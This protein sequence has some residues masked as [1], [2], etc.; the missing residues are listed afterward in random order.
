M[1][2]RGLTNDQVAQNF[3]TRQDGY[4]KNGYFRSEMGILYSFDMEIARW[5]D[6]AIEKPLVDSNWGLHQSAT[7]SGHLSVLYWAAYRQKVEMKAYLPFVS[8]TYES[9]RIYEVSNPF[10]VYPDKVD[11]FE[12][13]SK[14]SW[15]R[16]STAFKHALNALDTFS[17]LINLK[18][19]KVVRN[20]H[21][22][23]WH[24][25]LVGSGFTKNLFDIN[26]KE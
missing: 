6:D 23:H 8:D 4:S 7:T 17:F 16:E 2:T 11:S 3:V 18:D 10:L 26:K 22:G 24:A 20:R 12:I 14:K 15:H 9:G 13:K 21:D 5:N 19:T 1:V 25:V